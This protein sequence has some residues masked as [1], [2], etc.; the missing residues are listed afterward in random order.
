MRKKGK[1]VQWNNNKGFGF[2]A[3]RGGGKDKGDRLLLSL[4]ARTDTTS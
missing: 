2:I 1:I 3:P 4:S